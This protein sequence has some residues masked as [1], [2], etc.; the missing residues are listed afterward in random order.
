MDTAECILEIFWKRRS[1][2]KAKPFLPMKWN[3]FLGGKESDRENLSDAVHR[4]LAVREGLNLVHIL[5]DSQKRTEARGLAMAITGAGALTPLL[6]ITTI[7]CN[8][9]VGIRRI[10]DGC[11]GTFGRKENSSAK[12][13][14]RLAAGAGTAFVKWGRNGLL[15]P[16][17]VIQGSPI[18]PG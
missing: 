17:N 5:T 15:G 7:F 11:P 16:E 3:N 12:S 6:M 10:S 4:L 13:K 14:S 1:R 18:C 2:K 8:V 9:C